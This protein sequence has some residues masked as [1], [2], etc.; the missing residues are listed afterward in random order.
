MS[1]LAAKDLHK[2]FKAT[3][4]HSTIIPPKRGAVKLKI[5]VYGIT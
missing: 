4:R 3:L 1:L 2:D 5:V